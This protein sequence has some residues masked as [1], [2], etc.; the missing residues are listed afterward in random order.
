MTSR[1][2][3]WRRHLNGDA[4]A[5]GEWLEALPDLSADVIVKEARKKRSPAH[6]I[7]EWSDTAA[8]HEFR[9]VQARV[10]V[11]SLHVEVFDTQNEPIE[12]NAFIASSDRGKYVPVFEASENEL[13]AVEAKFL[14]LISGLESRYAHLQMAKPVIMAIRQVRKYASRKAA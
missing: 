7:F 14:D 4:Q 11:Q 13:T 12:V 5:V 9:L 3:K 2:Y 6:G 8:A 10:M 1:T